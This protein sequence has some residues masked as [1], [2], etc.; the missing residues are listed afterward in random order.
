MQQQ[1]PPTSG[2]L[3]RARA[4][5]AVCRW[6]FATSVERWPH[7]Y[8][9]RRWLPCERLAEFDWLE[10]LIATYGYAGWFWGQRWAY[11]ALG[12]GRKYWTSREVFGEGAVL[13]RAVIAPESHPQLPG[14]QD[15]R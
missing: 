15:E 7:E 3:D 8:S 2:E 9:L 11:L 5:V 14:L 1:D 6:Q 13:N 4:L 10:D 12:D